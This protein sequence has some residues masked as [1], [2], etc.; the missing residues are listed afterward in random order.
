MKIGLIVEG[1]DDEVAIEK[2]CKKIGVTAEIRKQR[3][4]INVKKACAYAKDL[5]RKGCEKV[6]ILPDAHCN[7]EGER[8]RLQEIYK[9]CG[10][11]RDRIHICVVV[12]ELESWLIADNKVLSE[13]IGRSIKI[14][15][16]EDVHDAKGYLREILRKVGKVYYTALAREIAEKIDVHEVLKKC[17]SFVEFYNKV[18]D[19]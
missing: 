16:P 10:E 17:R 9:L 8:K 11:L 18:R 5:I 1:N 13:Y 15:N 19:C 3:G 2:L 4:R 7:E 12:N 14:G 6:I